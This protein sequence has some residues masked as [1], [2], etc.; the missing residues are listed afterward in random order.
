M[1]VPGLENPPTENKKLLEWVEQIAAL[2][3]PDRVE[4]G[5]GSQAEWDR[6]T[7]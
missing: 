4:W 2:A 1:T 5:D 7:S 6:L 3:Q